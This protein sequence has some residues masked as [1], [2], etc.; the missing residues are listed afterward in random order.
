MSKQV[1]RLGCGKCNHGVGRKNRAGNRRG[2]FIGWPA[3]GQIHCQNRRC[4]L[5]H[6]L[7]RSQRHAFHRRL[8]TGPE[9]CVDNQIRATRVIA[10][11]QIRGSR[12]HMHRTSHR[13]VQ[14]FPGR[15]RIAA[16]LLRRAEQNRCHIKSGVG[17]LPR[18]HHA[19]AAVVTGAAKH[20]DAMRARILATRKRRHCRR[21]RPHQFN[22]RN[23]EALAGGAVASLHLG[24]GKNVH[25]NHG[26]SGS[27]D[28]QPS[29]RQPV[30]R[31]L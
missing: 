14:F 19:V 30:A 10:L 20:G 17:K 23:T 29:S 5:A 8:K 1:R 12:S 15:G 25:C 27:S 21:S 6:P 11:F 7:K 2:R 24:C 4:T 28:G 18:S 16:E 13:I 3:G 9:H 22:G 26:N 31:S